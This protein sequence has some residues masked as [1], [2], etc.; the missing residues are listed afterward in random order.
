VEDM[1]KST[2]QKVVQS[3]SNPST[4]NSNN[5]TNSTNAN[6]FPSSPSL[7]A[8]AGLLKAPPRLSQTPRR[9]SNA[10]IGKTSRFS[11]ASHKKDMTC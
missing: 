1:L 3:N 4:P 7:N 5:A 9:V 2:Q 10:T 6:K 11:L 8:V